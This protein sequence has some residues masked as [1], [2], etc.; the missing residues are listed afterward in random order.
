MTPLRAM[1]PRAESVNCH[2][3]LGRRHEVCEVV[4]RIVLAFEHTSNHIASGA[5]RHHR[6][7]H[8]GTLVSHLPDI[9]GQT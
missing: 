8:S 9:V 6:G 5:R 2:C 1:S 4:D 7:P 3:W